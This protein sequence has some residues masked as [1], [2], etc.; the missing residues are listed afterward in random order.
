MRSFTVFVVFVILFCAEGLHAQAPDVSW[1]RVIGDTKADEGYSVRQTTDGGYIVAGVTLSWGAGSAD[2]YLI[3]TDA[4]GD[5]LWTKTFGGVT[6][7]WAESVHQTTDGG[8]IVTGVTDSYGAGNRDVYLIRTDAGGNALWTKTI[9]GTSD[10]EGYSVQQTADGGYI[11]VGSTDSYGAGD[12][13]VYLIKTN[14]SGDTLWTKTIGG[15]NT[16]AGSFVQQTTDGGYI[17]TGSTRSCGAG[18]D[19]VYLIKT[20]SSGDTQWTKTIGG[21]DSDHGY[22][23]QQTTDGG[24]IIAGY[25]ESCGAGNS[26]VYLIKTDSSG[27]T[28]WTKTV[29]GSGNDQGESVQQTIDGGYILTGFTNSSGAGSYDVYIIKTD[30]SGDTLWTKV[31][32]GAGYDRC[33]SI[34]QTTDGGYIAAGL[35]VSYGAGSSD[36]YLI[37]LEPETGIEEE[38]GAN[39]LTILETIGPNPFSSDLTITYSIPEQSRVELAIFDLSGRLVEELISDLLPAGSHTVLW[40]PSEEVPSGCYLI[41]LS[42]CGHHEAG[43]CLK[44]N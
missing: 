17:L 28:L 37:K 11:V 21:A 44:L 26:D 38:T 15:V 20:N 14:S 4:S 34:R 29:G 40:T 36:V 12:S 35:T 13:D 2:V 31:I 8:F 22:Y 16:E 42:A 18:N 30:S 32:G 9:G 3:K 19:D 1:T 10:D 43:R 7:D 23:V 25:T 39:P 41:E 33:N 6:L 5:T 27:N 24:Y